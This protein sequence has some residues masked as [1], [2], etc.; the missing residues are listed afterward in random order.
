VKTFFLKAVLLAV[1]GTSVWT[2]AAADEVD[3][4]KATARK[5]YE[6]ATAKIA[7][8][9]KVTQQECEKFSGPAA[10]ACRIQ[11]QAKRQEAE[12]DAKVAR[13]RAGQVFP[14]PNKD[15]K[16]AAKEA[17]ARAKVDH[18]V[19]EARIHE[20]HRA[21]EAE[22]DKVLTGQRKDCKKDVA[23]RSNEAKKREK[24]RYGRAV[25]DAKAIAAP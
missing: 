5:D 19:A 15:Q 10:Q 11:V 18:S 21:A 16:K 12:E 14:L 4:A 25:A 9:D 3:T 2:N 22:C 23:A 13:D 1:L 20:T 6:S 17:L 8:D 24:F 7:A